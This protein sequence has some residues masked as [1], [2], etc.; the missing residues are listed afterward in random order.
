[1]FRDDIRKMAT[2]VI[3]SSRNTMD[4]QEN[5]QEVCTA[6]C[7]SIDNSVG[8]SSEPIV[9]LSTAVPI[10]SEHSKS[11]TAPVDAQAQAFL[12]GLNVLVVDGEFLSLL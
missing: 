10:S 3:Q 9:P 4:G 11:R 5:S 2:E 8:K 7:N 1:V 12:S 6:N